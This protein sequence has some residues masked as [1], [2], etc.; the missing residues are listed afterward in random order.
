VSGAFPVLFCDLHDNGILE[1]LL[2]RSDD[3]TV[4]L[5]DDIMSFAVGGNFP[6]LT[7]WVQL[8]LVDRRFGLW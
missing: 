1:A 7:P 5:N 3:W 4:S 6:L 8:N 2:F